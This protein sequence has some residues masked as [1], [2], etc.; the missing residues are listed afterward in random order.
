M[1]EQSP[2]RLTPGQ[3]RGSQV[4][5]IVAGIGVV[6]ALVVAFTLP[7]AWHGLTGAVA[8]AYIAW[9]NWNRVRRDRR[10]DTS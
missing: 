6:A 10:Q 5:A 4:A 8:F 3:A 7:P 2:E 1:Q 9:F